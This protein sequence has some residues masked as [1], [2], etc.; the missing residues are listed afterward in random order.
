MEL[1]KKFKKSFYAVSVIYIFIGLIMILNPNFVSDAVNYVIGSLVIL[2]GLVYVI[3][4]YQKK[5][6]EEYGKFDL[7]A[8]VLCISF[9]LFLIVHKDVLVSLIPF[10]LGVIILIDAISGIIRGFTFKKVGVKNWWIT[11]LINVLFLGFAIYIIIMAK[12][13]TELFIRIIGGVL[14]FDAILD[15]ITSI[16]LNKKLKVARENIKVI[17][18]EYEEK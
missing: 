10:C 16:I 9:G 5:E 14:V 11:L 2:Y 7:L 4:I 3:S 6:Y 13:I 12:D 18:T 15:L 17:E 1:L 8:G